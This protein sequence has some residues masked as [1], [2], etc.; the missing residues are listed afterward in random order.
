MSV[1]TRIVQRR[2]ADLLMAAEALLLLSFFRA[3]LA[4]M[5]VRRIIRAVTHGKASPGATPED[6]IA[7]PAL[8]TAL[9]IRWAIEA[10]IR[11][12]PAEF[13]CFPQT[14]AGYTML[15][16]R[17]VSS[18]MVYGVARSPEGKLIAHTW[19][20]LGDRT[21]LGGEGAGAFSEVERWN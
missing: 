1:L 14:L 11:H 13:V 18:A 15:R 20:M 12:S 17:G 7:Q 10:I 6:A 21:V 8:S 19:L 2:P 9:R 16:W 3:S 5:P 4:L